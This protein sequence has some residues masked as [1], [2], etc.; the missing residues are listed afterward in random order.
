MLEAMRAGA[1]VI[2]ASGALPEVL[3]PYAH[4]FEAD[5]ADALCGLLVRALEDP[6]SFAAD[7]HAAQTATS[8]LTW[9]RTARAT[10]D[11]YREFLA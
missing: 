7:A 2:A 5:D 4:A 11:V 9:A 3:A 1:P 6:T 8:E 10:A